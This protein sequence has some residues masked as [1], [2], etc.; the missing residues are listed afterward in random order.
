MEMIGGLIKTTSRFAIAAAAS[1]I[2][3]SAMAADLG[4]NC[5]AD[6][7]ERVAEL[8]A[9]AARKGNRR[10]SLTVYGQ[11]NEGILWWD[12]GEE[13]NA[14]VVTNENS[15]T[16]FG[17]RGDATISPEWKA[18]YLLEI[19]VRIA[20]SANVNQFADDLVGGTS[21]LDLRHSAWWIESNRLGRVWVGHTSMATDGI[22][23]INLSNAAQIGAP[24]VNNWGG[25]MFLRL[26]NGTLLAV[27]P[28]AGL[29]WNDILSQA[30]ANVGDGDRR[31]LVRYVSPTFSGFT[32]SASWGEDDFW[33]AALRYANEWNGIRVAAGIGY[34]Q[35]TD[36]DATAVLPTDIFGITG[37]AVTGTGSNND[38]GCADLDFVDPVFGIGVT[39]DSDVDCWAVGMSASAMHVPTGL[40]IAG[41]YGFLKD[42]NRR[43][44]FA[45]RALE[46][47]LL[48]PDVDDRDEFWYVQAGIEKNFFGLGNTTIYG[49]YFQADTGGGLAGGNVNDLG[50]L[51]GTLPLGANFDTFG[52]AIRSSQVT[53]WGFGIVQTIDAAA[54]D[55][56]AGYRNYSGDFD[57]VVNV[58][59]SPFG[60]RLNLD[61]EDYQAVF[62]GGIIRF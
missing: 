22:T 36:G 58:G 11:V 30:N 52:A 3:T 23:E 44:L 26:S 29:Q 21:S 17:F 40:Y 15:R 61:V 62:T 50:F 59:A 16:R 32:F 46:G 47:N 1:V 25:G 6:L 43:E 28:F 20:N 31:N 5:C 60:T 39:G 33:D 54:M 13:T 37:F 48:L 27:A 42:E 57:A 34:Q 2:A 55:L 45:L 35:W 18:G 12:D 8:E 56:Y 7:E 41:A 19:G 53:V 24:D 10:V 9:T 51:A 38:R 14:Y 4:G 49:E